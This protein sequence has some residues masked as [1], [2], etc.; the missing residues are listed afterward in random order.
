MNTTLRSE[1]FPP[2]MREQSAEVARWR[3]AAGTF[4]GRAAELLRQSA[5]RISVG[6]V[7]EAGARSRPRRNSFATRCPPRRR[8]VE[9]LR[10]PL[11]LRQ[12]IPSSSGE[13]RSP[14]TVVGTPAATPAIRRW[15]AGRADNSIRTKRRE[16]G[17]KR[18]AHQREHGS[19]APELT[20]PH[21][22]EPSSRQGRQWK[23]HEQTRRHPIR[24][25]AITWP[26]VRPSD[27]PCLLSFVHLFVRTFVRLCMRVRER[28]I[29]RR[30]DAT[31]ARSSRAYGM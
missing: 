10:A 16:R 12:A 15:A 11:A 6:A 9:Q 18:Q 13:R 5:R 4:V 19:G 8:S 31:S 21:R 2:F 27:R 23:L 30:C 25:D 26:S 24:R 7:A 14:R 17:G 29:D 1:S 22:R 3:H 20:R 28:R